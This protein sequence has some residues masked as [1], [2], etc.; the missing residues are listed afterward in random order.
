MPFKNLVNGAAVAAVTALGTSVAM[1][2]ITITTVPVGNPGNAPDSTGY[3]AV[4]YAYNIGATEVT[5]AQYAAFLN[6]VA[7][8][9]TYNLYNPSMAG[10]QGGIARSGS[11]GSYTYSAVSGRASNPVNHVS[12]WDAA[13]FSNWLHNGQPIGP[14][15]SNTT[16][17]GA[18]TLTPGG[19]SANTVTRNAGWQWAVTSENEWYKAAYHQPA[20]LGG[21]IDDY[22]LYPTSTNSITT[23]QANYNSPVSNSTPVASYAA[24][25]YGAFDMGGNVAEWNEASTP[26]SRTL[27]GGSFVSFNSNDLRATSRLGAGPAGENLNVGFRVVQVPGPS[28]YALLMIGG[29]LAARRRR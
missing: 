19:I 2:S 27:R 17:D 21:D 15:N 20:G 23:A 26:A 16:E 3:G 4:A 29:M 22:W 9:D 12:F 18:Y 28:V 24:N 10:F 25:F 7:S 11:P 5:N 13:R 6:S 14:Q 8:T 1:G